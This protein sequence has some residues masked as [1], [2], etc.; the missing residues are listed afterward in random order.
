MITRLAAKSIH[1]LQPICFGQHGASGRATT[2]LQGRCRSW[3]PLWQLRFSVLAP[4]SAAAQVW[5]FPLSAQ[6]LVWAR[7]AAPVWA[8]PLSAL[9]LMR[10]AAVS[11]P[12]SSPIAPDAAARSWD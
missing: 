1:E 12:A 8:L 7:A 4:A 10:V 2:S 5:T 11:Q 3:L 9:A 6:A